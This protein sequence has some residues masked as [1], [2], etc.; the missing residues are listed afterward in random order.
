M[1][2]LKICEES[3]SVLQLH[4]FTNLHCIVLN[5]YSDPMVAARLN[6]ANS[7]SVLSLAFPDIAKLLET[8]MRHS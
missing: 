5:K 8:K 7:L 1:E 4:R 6:F 2:L 3:R